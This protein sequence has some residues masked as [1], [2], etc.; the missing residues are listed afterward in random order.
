MNYTFGGH[1]SMFG[2]VVF[3][4]CCHCGVM[5]LWDVWGQWALAS[6]PE[7]SGS[8]GAPGADAVDAQ[9]CH[10]DHRDDGGAQECAHDDRH[11]LVGVHLPGIL[12]AEGRQCP[13]QRFCKGSLEAR[14]VLLEGPLGQGIRKE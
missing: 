3:I 6:F 13:G 5:F 12:L 11:S 1:I 10:D 14:G 9:L 7:R 2:Y 4:M 8:G